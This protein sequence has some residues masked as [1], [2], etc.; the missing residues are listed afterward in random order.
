[1]DTL[2]VLKVCVRRWWVCLPIL[3]LAGVVGVSMSNQ[4][5]P[6]YMAY[7]SYAV[8]YDHAGAIQL[9]QP[10]PR[11]ANPL[12]SDGGLLLGET[13]V[14]ELT[15]PTTQA[16]YGNG[17]RGFAPGQSD[18]GAAFSV[19]VPQG[20]KSFLVQTWG[21]SEDSVRRTVEAV[22]KS[23]PGKAKAIQD[24]AGAPPLSQYTTFLTSPT[25]VVS[26]PPQS[27]IKVIL[28]F[29]GIGLIAGPALALVVDRLLVR[30]EH[31][32]R[33]SVRRMPRR[34]LRSAEG[35]ESGVDALDEVTS[36]P[37]PRAR[38]PVRGSSVGTL[39]DAGDRPGS[40]GMRPVRPRRPTAPHAGDGGGI[41]DSRIA[42]GADHRQSDDI[43][44]R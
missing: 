34:G 5:K 20:Q 32:K 7:G 24:R 39:A 3:V 2:D 43:V 1:M 6:E 18:T 25:Q 14:A 12:S 31:R 37:R 21:D 26:L 4:L 40:D 33:R 30:R 10:D 38:P 22:L 23:V 41:A 19:S 42:D 16:E 29:L 9:N 15:S 17:N 11:N 44:L 27:R 13:L 8:V 36:S 35:A 28:T